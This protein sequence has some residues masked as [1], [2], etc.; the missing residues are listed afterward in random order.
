MRIELTRD[1]RVAML[2]RSRFLKLARK[3]NPEERDYSHSMAA[4]WRA[5]LFISTACR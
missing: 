1:P 3:W 2:L 5:F 4:I